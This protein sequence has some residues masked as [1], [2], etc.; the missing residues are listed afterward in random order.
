MRNP[1]SR[2]L[3][4]IAWPGK[5]PMPTAARPWIVALAV[6]TTVVLGPLL[7]FSETTLR[8]LL[9]RWLSQC[10]VVIDIRQLSNDAPI[11]RIYTFGD[12]PPSLP[13]TF[14][15]SHGVIERVSLLNQV[16]QETTPDGLNLLVHPLANQRCPGDLCPDQTG[17]AEKLTVRLKPVGTNYSY[18]FRILASRAVTADQIRVYSRPLQEEVSSCRVESAAATNFLARQSPIS[19]AM[20]LF[21]AVAGLTLVVGFV[22]RRIGEPK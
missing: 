8:A 16:E 4:T 20:L 17:S 3:K 22:K 7:A 13:L 15:A 12:L 1:F 11:V 19:Q 9:D 14:A 18:Q 10:I 5:K 21:I 2:V 6:A